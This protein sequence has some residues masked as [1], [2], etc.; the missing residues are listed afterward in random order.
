MERVE[1]VA[2]GA[3]VPLDPVAAEHAD[4]GGGT[5]TLAS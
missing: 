4:F 1:R 3:L 5:A 2:N